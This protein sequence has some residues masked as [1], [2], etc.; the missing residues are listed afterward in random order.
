MR[1]SRPRRVV[2]Q[3]FSTDSYQTL[4]IDAQQRVRWERNEAEA[5][6]EEHVKPKRVNCNREMLR[7]DVVSY[8]L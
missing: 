2:L 4:R 6:F 5:F 7:E 1:V 8:D 3:C